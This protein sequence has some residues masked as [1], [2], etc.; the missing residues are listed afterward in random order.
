MENKLETV[1]SNEINEYMYDRYGIDVDKI[2][3]D[4]ILEEIQ[5]ETQKDKEKLK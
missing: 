5:N 4:A 1:W 3:C 2:I